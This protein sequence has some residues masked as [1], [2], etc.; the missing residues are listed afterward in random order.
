MES[1]L[2]VAIGGV[3][4]TVTRYWLGGLVSERWPVAFPIGT[5]VINVTGAFFLGFL[6][7]A[8]AEQGLVPQAWRL[9]FGVGFLGAYTTFSTWQV[10]TL[11]LL[12]QGSV[13][14][15]IGNVAASIALGLFAAWLG[16]WLGRAL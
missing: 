3:F 10:E 9:A 5:L 12:Q 11:R 2:F 8:G 1:Y 13:W 14:L 7:S 16:Y 6:T 4:G 15:G